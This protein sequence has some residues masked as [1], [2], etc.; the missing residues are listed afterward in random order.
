[1]PQPPTLPTT[2]SGLVVD[3][4]DNVVVRRDCPFPSLPPDQVL[5][6]VHAVGVNPSDTKMRGPFALPYAILGADFAGEII[7][8]GADVTHVQIGDRVCGAQ[9]E[10]FK[11]SPERGAF[12]EYNVTRGRM[13]MKIPDS[14]SYE[15]A[16]SLPVGLCTAG[17][18]LKL[19]G[20]PLPDRP[21]EKGV[22][23]L[24][25]GG[26]TATATIAM[27]LLKL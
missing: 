9:N 3:D 20:L 25:Y 7:A 5:V 12:A 16:A 14:L 22:H 17:L 1:M 27:Q 4:H 15:A 8:I 24:V 19:L 21:Q 10:L 6:R 18:A 23:V 2:Q 11:A 13:W 26:S